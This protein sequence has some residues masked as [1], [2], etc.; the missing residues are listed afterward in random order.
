MAL[1][2][3]TAVASLAQQQRHIFVCLLVCSF[4]PH[5]FICFVS[6]MI[7]LYC[8]CSVA[9]VLNC[10]IIHADFGYYAGGDITGNAV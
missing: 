3:S 4:T 6:L 7:L 8:C 10:C 2:A 9:A 5:F 1:L